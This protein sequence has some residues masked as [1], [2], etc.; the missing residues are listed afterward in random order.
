MSDLITF[1]DEIIESTDLI[2][3]NDFLVPNQQLPSYFSIEQELNE[4][5]YK[6]RLLEER[7][8]KLEE[9]SLNTRQIF[10]IIP[11]NSSLL[12]INCEKVNMNFDM[13]HFDC[14]NTC[15]LRYDN[16]SDNNLISKFFN[17]FQNIKILEFEFNN[18]RHLLNY[19]QQKYIKI[20][21]KI[22]QS[23]ID[24]NELEI[25]FKCSFIEDNFKEIFHEFMNTSINKKIILE[26]IFNCSNIMDIYEKVFDEFMKSIY[27]KNIIGNHIKINSNKYP[28]IKKDIFLIVACPSA[29]L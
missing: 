29:D 19:D 15:F 23:L 26:I 16:L 28:F 9:N 24:I 5:K 11:F 22:L 14:C 7:L 13:I 1:S 8:K 18:I 3:L 4:T 27:Y 20:I 25:I 12:D 21:C 2:S 10:S 17:Q 6:L